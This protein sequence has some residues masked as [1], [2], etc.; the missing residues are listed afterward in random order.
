MVEQV[1]VSAGI[2][3][4]AVMVIVVKVGLIEYTLRLCPAVIVVGGDIAVV[5]EVVNVAEQV[6]IQLSE[7]RLN[8]QAHPVCLD[9]ELQTVWQHGDEVLRAIEEAHTATRS[10]HSLLAEH[11]EVAQVALQVRG[12]KIRVPVPMKLL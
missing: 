9:T 7:A 11:D 1:V 6:D 3:L 12:Y 10:V 5:R 8:L 2:V 4:I